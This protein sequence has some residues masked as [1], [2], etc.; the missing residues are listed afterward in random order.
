MHDASNTSAT[1]EV[2]GA[3]APEQE[4]ATG[5]VSRKAFLASG[6]AVGVGASLGPLG[7]GV[8][9]LA[10]FGG[11]RLNEGDEAILRFLA[12]AELLETDLWQQYNELGGIQDKRGS[13]RQR[14]QALQGSPASARR[15][16]A[17]VHPRQHRRR[18]QPR[19]SSSTPT[20]NRGAAGP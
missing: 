8:S 2:N 5:G 11:G 19:G 12:A 15:R 3:L 16:H 14:Q 20:S 7:Q 18:D 10:D 6:V 17:A 9:A 13:G 4:Q 1:A